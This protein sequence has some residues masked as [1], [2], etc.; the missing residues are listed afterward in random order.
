MEQRTGRVALLL[1][2]AFGLW[3]ATELAWICD[4]AFLSLRYADNLLAGH[5]LVFNPGEYVEGYTNLLWTLLIAAAEGLG[6][7]PVA[8]SQLLGIMAYLALAAALAVWSWRLAGERDGV[9]LPLAAM[10][11]LALSDFHEWATGGL[12]TSLFAFLMLQALLLTRA[13]E[14]RAGRALAAGGLLGLLVLT[15]L[16]GL[17]VAGVAVLSYALP[18]TPVP[19]RT[20]LR[21]AFFT[22]LPVA[23][24]LAI[25]M[26]FKLAYYG[27][28]FPTAFYSKSV[29]RPYVTQ[30]VVY[31]L[32]FLGHNWLV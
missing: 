15:R 31:A 13:R 11:V 22:A 21:L 7:P 26:P 10:L 19:W 32:L 20:R 3:R 12:E 14:P 18:A 9:F 8:A 1:L 17:L 24:V 27:D 25:W 23:L 16:D 5:G 30:G 4:D 29:T 6:A 2:G 28:L